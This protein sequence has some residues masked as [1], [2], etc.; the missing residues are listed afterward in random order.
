M[1]DAPV[2]IPLH[3]G[4][5]GKAVLAFAPEWLDEI[6][7]HNDAQGR[8]VK[9]SELRKTLAAIRTTEFA[10]AEGE[11]I[12]GAFGVAAPVFIDGKIAGS[13]TVTTPRYGVDRSRIPEVAEQVKKIS[14]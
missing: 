2:G 12:P 5:A 6:D 4:A 14:A 9:V 11:R 10:I 13:L 8:K 3:L 1:L 7:M